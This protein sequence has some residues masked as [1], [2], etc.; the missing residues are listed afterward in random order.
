MSLFLK[1]PSETVI[2]LLS[3]SS[4]EPVTGVLP[5]AVTLKIRKNGAAS[6]TTKPLAS[7]SFVEISEGFYSVRWEAA[8]LDTLGSF[9]FTLS[10]SGVKAVSVFERIV[11]EPF[12]VNQPS[13][14]CLVTGSVYEL[15]GRPSQE[16]IVFRAQKLPSAVGNALTSGQVVKTS[17]DAF[18]NFSAS[19]LRGAKVIVEMER[20]G[21]KHTITVPDLP[22]ASLTSLLPQ[23][24]A[25]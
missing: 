23:I 8:D 17:T 20:S 14:T 4:S 13:L 12:F 1:K 25:T 3:T 11:P 2:Q 10:S 21:L 15:D 9:T 22:A 18:G 19:L 5:S 6:F 24:Q 16:S 7:D